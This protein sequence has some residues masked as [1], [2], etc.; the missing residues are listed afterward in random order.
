MPSADLL[1]LSGA[2]GD[3]AVGPCLRE[4]DAALLAS[5]ATAVRKGHIKH[6]GAIGRYARGSPEA[7]GDMVMLAFWAVA[8]SLCGT[9]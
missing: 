4:C 2:V 3:R 6:D 7:V 8:W 1:V 9:R 5:S